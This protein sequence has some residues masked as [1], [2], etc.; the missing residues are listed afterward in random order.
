MHRPSFLA[1]AGGSLAAIRA[2]A[3]ESL[4]TATQSRAGRSAGDIAQDEDF[5]FQVRQAFTID[6]N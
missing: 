1:V 3:F 6:R 5:W 2:N 4:A